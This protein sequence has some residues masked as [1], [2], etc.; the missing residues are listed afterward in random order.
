M[1]VILYKEEGMALPPK[2]EIK[3]MWQRNPDGAGIMWQTNNG[4]VKFAKGFMSLKSFLKFIYSGEDVLV[5]SRLAMHFRITTHGGTSKGNT[6]PFVI[7]SSIDSHTLDGSGD[8][9]L[10]HNGMLSLTPRKADISDSAELALRASSYDCPRQF[11]Q[12]I[13]D[14]IGSNKLIIFTKGEKPLL[15]GQ[16]QDKNGYK[17]SNLNHDYKYTYSF[18]TPNY[19][20]SNKKY[21]NYYGDYDYGF[22]SGYGYNNY[23]DYDD[24]YYASQDQE[25][26]QQEQDSQQ[27]PYALFDWAITNWVDAVTGQDIPDEDIVKGKY[28]IDDEDYEILNLMKEH[29]I[30]W[31]DEIA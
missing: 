10:M 22:G 28:I 8:N 23:D 17:Y 24:G 1:C 15:V 25:L 11:I 6:H 3:A 21:C 2:K 7:N 27:E 30:S 31:R 9:I 16:W 14:M 20:S 13:S 19:C 12:N 29:P 26:D 18:N 4:V 5:K